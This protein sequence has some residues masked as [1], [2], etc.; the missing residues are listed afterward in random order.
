MAVGR[1]AVDSTRIVSE[2][3]SV[4]VR[5]GVT[6]DNSTL[7]FSESTMENVMHS[8]VVTSQTAAE[9]SVSSVCLSSASNIDA[10][11]AAGNPSVPV[12]HSQLQSDIG[13]RSSDTARDWSTGMLVT[14]C[15]GKAVEVTVMLF[16]IC[17]LAFSLD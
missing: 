11:P 10:R 9:V 7:Q 14:D 8:S 17:R 15:S 6:Q 2:D 12:N 1:S 3:L 16:R 4:D 13:F 5:N